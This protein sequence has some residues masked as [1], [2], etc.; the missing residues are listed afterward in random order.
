MDKED[1]LKDRARKAM[2]NIIDNI[3]SM[4]L[5]SF[6]KT[7]AEMGLDG[8]ELTA[9]YF[10]DTS[11][12]YLQE[13]KKNAFKYGM[14]I[15][16]TA[17]GNNFCQADEKVRKEQIQMVKD[18]IDHSVI[19]GSPCIRVF[20]G[21]V[22]EGYTEK[23]AFNWTVECVKECVEYG[24]KNGVVIALENHGGI[25]G[26]AD[27]VIKLMGE[28]KSDWLGLN[29]DFGNFRYPWIEFEKVAKYAVTTH[30]KTHY[31]EG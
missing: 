30:S 4:S 15:A 20:A 21:Y 10:K 18:W 13:V 25:T 27:Q 8:V 6:I 7:C 29:L 23:D 9:Y 14:H 3:E 17:V 16:G 26:T 2:R 24:E 11:I 1:E 19:L 12:K 28:I 5:E 31:F 22:P